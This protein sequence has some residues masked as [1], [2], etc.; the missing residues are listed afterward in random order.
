MEAATLEIAAQVKD[1]RLELARAVVDSL[2]GGDELKAEL[3]VNKLSELYESH[4]FQEIGKLTRELHDALGFCRDDQRITS[5]TEQEIPDARERLNYVIKKTEESANRTLDIVE[6]LLPISNQMA[7]ESEYMQKDWQRF[8]RREMDI[9]EFR[10]LSV[11]LEKYFGT[12]CDN[13]ARIKQDLNNV[14]LAQDFQDLTGQIIRQV[15]N[16]VQEVEDKL[17]SVIR[18]ARSGSQNNKF[19]VKQK[20]QKSDRIKAQGPQINEENNPDV[21]SAQDDVDDLLSSLGF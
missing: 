21:I 4:L 8:T 1:N 19:D 18:N 20:N 5:L 9:E 10:K 7:E 14:M 13:A 15:I 12:A 17:V 2:E 3:A 6:N 11:R 16:L